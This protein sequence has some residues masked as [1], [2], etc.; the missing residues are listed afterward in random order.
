MVA[1]S[2]L[3]T[4]FST[5]FF[6]TLSDR[7]G[8][9]KPFIWLGYIIWGIFTVVFGTTGYLNEILP[10]WVMATMVIITDCIMSFFGS[11]GNDSG[12]NAWTADLVD[13][14]NQGSIGAILAILPVAGTIVGTLLGGVVIENW[15]Y[16][17]FFAIIGGF[18]ILVGLLSLLVLK[19]KPGLAPSV[20]GSFWQQFKEPFNFK[21]LKQ[22]KE[23]LFVFI[24]AALF[25]I[26]FNVFYMHIGNLLIYNYGFSTMDS[27]FIQGGGMALALLSTIPVGRAINKQKSPLMV[28]MGLLLSVVSLVYLGFVAPINNPANLWSVGNLAL[29]IGVIFMAAGFVIF[30][31]TSSVWVKALYPE[32]SAGQFEGLR[33]LFFVLIPMTLSG[34]VSEPIIQLL[35]K[36]VM[37]EVAPGVLI[38]GRAPTEV[39]FFAGAI[40][41]ATAFIPLVKLWKHHN[42]RIKQLRFSALSLEEKE[43]DTPNTPIFDEKGRHANSGYAKEFNFTYRRK[44]VKKQARLKEWDFYQINND[45]YVV[46]LTIG[47]ISFLQN[48]A[49][50]IMDLEAKTRKDINIIKLFKGKSIGLNENPHDDHEVTLNAK[51][52]TLTF[53][54]IG[55]IRKLY[56]SA[57]DK[58]GL[59]WE[60]NFEL[61]EMPVHQGMSINTP[62]YQSSKHFY[63]NYKINNLKTTGYLKIGDE[64]YEFA[65]AF[66]VLD[67]GRGVWPY[68]ENW[69][70]GSM[71]DRLADGRQI[72]LNTGYGFGDLT[73]AGENM[74]F[75]DGKAHKLNRIYQVTPMENDYMAPIHLKDDAGTVDLVLTPIYDRYNN[76]DFKVMFMKC[77]QI[78]CYYSGTITLNSGEKVVLDNLLGFYE[79]AH[80]RW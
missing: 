4:T 45:R 14:K 59:A 50:S 65:D 2:A 72:G 24:I 43:I 77:H 57:V 54:K 48:G 40:I 49:L 23:L 66:G 79:H 52:F 69:Y 7:Q 73:A 13:E 19:D 55:K 27:G 70:W 46:Q 78:H 41:I 74:L 29:F 47:H 53:S 36:D 71:S 31:Q 20:R 51:N 76:T 33:V 10:L 60:I 9:R 18:V 42:E 21:K 67:W 64:K 75:L 3:V 22:H 25:S 26:G 62:F 28:F 11:M 6:G 17:A 8:K 37:L 63:L 16:L 39:L 44:E 1:F 58:D 12:L 61:E 5:F 38:E 68:D 34:I 15:G 35:G 56:G 80:N 30:I 32:G